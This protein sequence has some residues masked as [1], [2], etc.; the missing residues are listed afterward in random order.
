MSGWMYRR[1]DELMD[2]RMKVQRRLQD[3]V[4]SCLNLSQ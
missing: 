4:E 3:R 1:M 2:G